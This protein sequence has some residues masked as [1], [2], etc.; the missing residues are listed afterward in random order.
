LWLFD[1]IGILA[2][3]LSFVRI[4]GIALGSAMLAE[5]FNGLILNVY[6][7][8]SGLGFLLGVLVG[9]L[10]SIPLHIINLGFSSLSPFIHSLRL[11]MYELSSKFYEGSG[12][13]ISPA[14]TPLF[15]VKIGTIG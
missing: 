10:I 7:S 5:I 6:S 1:L 2:D 11:V 13:R 3:V 4:A 15:R 9:A 14:G 8:L 12:R